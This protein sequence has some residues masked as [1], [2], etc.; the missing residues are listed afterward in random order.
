M[1]D[2]AACAHCGQ[3]NLAT[4]RFCGACGQAMARTCPACGGSNPAGFRFCGSCGTNLEQSPSAAPPLTEERRLATVLFADLSGFTDYSERTD[5]EDVQ[6]MVDHCM[7]RM[8]DAVERFGA[9]VTRVVGDELMALFGAP[10]SHEDD[11]ERAVRAGLEIQ[12][13]AEEHREEFAGLAVRVGI[14]TGEMMF[15]PVGPDGSFTVMGDAVNVAARLQTAAP[16]GG[17][18]V[19]PET[20]ASS[21]RAIDYEPV[22]P[23]ALK[24][25][26]DPVAAALALGPAAVRPDPGEAVLPMIG[27]DS[28]LGLLRTTWERVRSE[29]SPHLVTVLGAPGVGKTRLYRE[30][31]ASVR[32]D[33]DRIVSGRSFPYGESTG[34]GAFAQQLR[35][36][37]GIFE[38]DSVAVA[39][40]KLTSAVTALLPAGAAAVVAAH[41]AQMTGLSEESTADKGALLLSARRLTEALALDRP[42][43]LIFEDLHWA[44]PT[45]FDLVESL[46]GRCRDVPLMVL[47]LARPELLDAR[48]GWGGGLPSHTNLVLPEL[49]LEDSRRLVSQ[50][51]PGIS[52]PRVL[53]RLVERAGGNPLFLEE[54]SASLEERV[55]ETAVE[56]PTSVRATIAARLDALPGAERQL[57]LDASVIGRVFWGGALARLGTYP[58]DLSRLLDSLEARDF[59]RRERRSGIEGDEQFSFKHV[60]IREVAYGTLPRAARRQRH[61]AVARF[62]EEL[63]GSYLEEAG[64]SLLAHHWQ[65]AGDPEAAVRYLLIAAE[66]AA[67]AWAKGEAVGLLTQ[68]L[69]LIPESDAALRRTV[70]LRRATMRLEEADVVNA[71]AE[72]DSLLPELTDR[73]EVEGLVTRARCAGLLHDAATVVFGEQAIEL[74]KAGG[75]LDLIGPAMSMVSMGANLAGRPAESLA[76]ARQALEVWPAGNRSSDLGF[77]MGIAGLASYYLGRHDEAIDF[78]RRGVDLAEEI[79]NGE[80][81]LFDG[82]QMVLGLT[83]AGRHE[84][85]LAFLEPLVAH[86][87]ELGTVL[88]WTARAINIG[89]GTLRELHALGEART[90]NQEAAEIAARVP[91]PVA[92]A[93]S[94]VDLLFV[95]LAEGE[96][97]KAGAAWP[98]LW[99]AAQGLKGFHQW[100]VSCRLEAARAEIALGIGDLEAAATHAATALASAQRHGR[101]K[102]EVMAGLVMAEALTG[103]GRRED[104]AAQARNARDASERLG[105]PPTRWQAE[106]TLS[107][108][109]AAAGD[110]EGAGA[111]L[112]SARRV[113]GEFA[114]GLSGPRRSL[115]LAAEPVAAILAP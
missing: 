17:V 65:E 74:A 51:L 54:L 91:Y 43:V 23:L 29:R 87:L 71:A 9:S 97:G 109:L 30:F 106:A 90:R 72:L 66:S 7:R 82:G 80:T 79:H 3:E 41:L 42:T 49:S 46:A 84:E 61:A 48:P 31:A 86:A 85:A 112:I 81:L 69:D 24:G 83:G 70:R 88:P 107:R 105:H 108:V 13:L 53:E 64:A 18:L 12:R 67:R 99:E 56:L 95:D 5:P 40:G 101:L 75:H 8:G 45:L 68:A 103:L 32:A 19:G 11:A 115:L 94:E 100:L 33:G 60:L 98:R 39:G 58:T 44:D 52:D 34:W 37:A 77:C 111:A 26:A 15:A 78:G 62:F 2:T 38:T 114:A 4:Q 28:E 96:L 59:I 20:A 47:V 102:Y 35:T 6:V 27:R 73:E 110:D 16:L 1:A 14:N 92:I 113:I 55:A 22:E 36:L 50:L 104:G 21:A 76:I 93:Q 10:V 25:K 63:A 89:A 57:L